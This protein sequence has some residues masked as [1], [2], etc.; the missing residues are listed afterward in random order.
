M[1]R[2]KKTLEALRK[3]ALK[4]GG[5]L[6]SSGCFGLVIAVFC[7]Q[8]RGVC[9]DGLLVFGILNSFVDGNSEVSFSPKIRS[10]FTKSNII[11]ISQSFSVW[12]FLN[13]FNLHIEVVSLRII[14]SL[15]IPLPA[16]TLRVRNVLWF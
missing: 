11:L 6:V 10:D 1:E 12:C 16:S 2:F 3:G 13:F 7:K 8:R 14:A 15:R 5:L 4:T 9:S